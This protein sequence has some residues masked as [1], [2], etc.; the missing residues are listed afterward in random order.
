M[1]PILIVAALAASVPA[2]H[3]A[4]SGLALAGV[5]VD[6]R[7]TTVVR[8]LPGGGAWRSEVRVGHRIV[9][10]DP[11]EQAE[12]W[13]LIAHDG[14]SEV[15]VRQAGMSAELRDTA[16]SAVLALVAAVLAVLL[17]P[18]ARRGAAAVAVL[19]L[20]LAQ[21]P[22]MIASDEL[23]S[24]LAAVWAVAA[25]VAWLT[26]WPPFTKRWAVAA[27]VGVAGLIAG[28]WVL[29]RLAAPDI[30]DIIDGA[31]AGLAYLL[32]AT[33][34][35]VVVREAWWSTGGYDLH[36][37][38][39]VAVLAAVIAGG[40]V[41]MLLRVPRETVVIISI[42]A[43]GAYPI[44]RGKLR[45]IAGRL[46]LGRARERA[47]IVARE[48]ER[49]R[50]ARDLHDDPLQAIAAVLHDI[51]AHPELAAEATT[52]RDVATKLRAITGELRLPVLEDLGLSAAVAY[53]AGHVA[54]KTGIEVVAEVESQGDVDAARPPHEVELALFRI[55]Q[56]ALHNAVAHSA[57]DRIV[58]DGHVGPKEVHLA[59]SDDGVGI[60]RETLRRAE[61]AGHMG[62]HSI[63]QRAALIDAELRIDS[64]DP[65]TRV[66]VR[67]RR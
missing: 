10:L 16:S 48:E 17:L 25:P 28:A 57:A 5:E 46:L 29:A 47:A 33:I 15:F 2:I 19:A 38:A 62:L 40:V 66:S 63:R 12:D 54:D 50:L 4:V 49:G 21:H 52:L 1:A 36:D 23:P 45:E 32:V 3:V 37:R 56:E 11:G 13:L 30:Y 26:A 59:V 14:D 61:A 55:V 51:E 6:D 42:I 24:A 7:M 22:F 27:V 41:A 9:S 8:V 64:P 18:L 44:V 20:V 60:D 34:G 67:W 58:I 65:G 31:R 53:L 39:D 43:L 35:L